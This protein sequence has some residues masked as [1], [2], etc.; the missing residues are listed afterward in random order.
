VI[1]AEYQI[2]ALA[3][4]LLAPLTTV[5]GVAMASSLLCDGAG[6]LYNPGSVADLGSMLFDVLREINPLSS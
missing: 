1:D 5:R 2:R 6:P 4:A 3:D